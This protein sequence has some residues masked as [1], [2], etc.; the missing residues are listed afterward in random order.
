MRR[1]YASDVSVDVSSVTLPW[2]AA[3]TVDPVARTVSWTQE[4][5]A[6]IDAVVASPYI[7]RGGATFA[8]VVGVA[9]KG[10]AVTLPLLPAPWTDY[11][12]AVGDEIA[13]TYYFLKGA[14]LAAV[15]LADPREFLDLSRAE[16]SQDHA[17]AFV[18]TFLP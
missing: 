7:R 3:P 17:A 1:P 15:A 18:R 9:P 12:L 14:E 13:G 11:N 4:T 16:R 10:P 8:W 2:I 5:A 6:S